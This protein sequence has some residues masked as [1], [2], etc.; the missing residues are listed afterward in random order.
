M[1][2]KFAS[3]L[4]KRVLS[5][6]LSLAM[7]VTLLPAAE[8]K[9]EPTENQLLKARSTNG[10]EGKTFTRNQPFIS[11]ITGATEDGAGRPYFNAP[12]F[13]V[14]ETLNDS[15]I[16]DCTVKTAQ[17][18]VLIAAAE[19]RFDQEKKAGGTDVIAAVSK[20]QGAT[21]TYSYPLRF[22]DSEGN[23]GVHATSINN[24]TLTVAADG[25][26]YCLMNVTPTGVSSLA[27]TGDG[28]KYPNVGTGYIE[29][30]G[31]QRLALTTSTATADQS[32]DTYAYYVA[33]WNPD[34]GLAKVLSVSSN[35]ESDYAVD[36]WYNLYKK[37]GSGEY[38]E[39]TQKRADS[40]GNA[41][42]SGDVQQNVFYAGSELHVYNTSYVVCVTSSDGLSWSAP[43]ILNPYVKKADGKSLVVAGGKGLTTSKN[44][45]VFPVYRNNDG[46]D[47]DGTS[48]VI[49]L[50]KSTGGDGQWHRSGNVPNFENAEETENNWIGE[51]EIVELSDGKLRMVFRN[52]QGLISY[53]DAQ[54]NAQNEFVFSA[55]VVTGTR[56][57]ERAHPSVISYLNPIEER[58]G[59]LIAAPVGDNRTHG[60]IMTFLAT[61]AGVEG[62]GGE[63]AV[64]SGMT[65]VEGADVPGSDAYFQNPCMDQFDAGNK[66]GLLWENG[67]GSIRFNKFGILDVVKEHYIP[68]V[69]VDL[70]M[71][72]GDVY[73]RSYTVV[74][75]NH[76]NGV[77]Q[78]PQNEDGTDDTSV[79]SVEFEKGQTVLETVPA[80]YSRTT[81]DD[82]ENGF[83]LVG[84]GSLSDTFLHADSDI[85]T[86]TDQTIERAEFTIT[87]TQSA[88]D[89][90]ERYV[91][92]APLDRRYFVGRDPKLNF[93]AV[94][95][96]EDVIITKTP[97]KYTSVGEAGKIGADEFAILLSGRVNMFNVPKLRFDGQGGWH[98]NKNQLDG[99]FTFLQKM[100]PDETL[101]GEDAALELIPGYKKVT[102]ITPN[103]KYLITFIPKANVQRGDYFSDESI[104]PIIV[105]YPRNGRA[106]QTK[107]VYGTRQVERR[108][109]KHLKITANGEGDATVVANHITYNVHVH[110][111]KLEMQKGEK[112]FFPGVTV[113]QFEIADSNVATA[114]T[115][116]MKEPSLFNCLR[117]ANNSLDGYSTEANTDINM[118]AAEFI[119]TAVEGSE[120]E[121]YTIQSAV[122]DKYLVNK[123]AQE[124]FGN[125]VITQKV[126]RSETLGAE[127]FEIRR[128]SSD[129][130]NGRYVY[131]YYNRMAF[132]AVDRKI[133]AGGVDMTT[134]GKFDFELLEKQEYPT[135][136]D[137]ISGYRRVTKITSGK[138]YLITQTY[139]DDE[140]GE[141]RFVLYPEN[142]ITAQ[143]KMYQDVETEGVQLKA[144]GNAGSK[145]TVT[146]DSRVY[147]LTVLAACD[148]VGYG[149][150]RIGAV[151][152]TCTKD[153]YEG[154]LYC[155]HCDEKIADGA[156]IPAGHDVPESSWQITTQP[157]FEKDGEYTGTCNRC[158]QE[159]TKTYTKEEYADRQ[160]NDKVVE[161]RALREAD[162]T[163]KSYAVL[164]AALAK[165][166]SVEDTAAAK[167]ALYDEITTAI[168]GLERLSEF[169]AAK[170]QLKT[171]LVSM[172]E[173]LGK[174]QAAFDPDVWTALNTAANELKADTIGIDLSGLADAAA[175]DAKLDTLALSVLNAAWEK[176]KDVSTN[177][178]EEAQE[179]AKRTQL[180]TDI[181]N[182]VNDA[183]PIIE[184]G[185]KNYTD[186]SWK[187]LTDA[188]NAANISDSSLNGKTTK[189]LEDLLTN[190]STAVENLAEKEDDEMVAAKE[191][192][193]EA[194]KEADGIVAAG[195]KNYSKATWDAFVAA[196][197]AAKNASADADAA[198]LKKL[199]EDLAKAQKALKVETG[200]VN[201]LVNGM[202]EDVNQIRYQVLDASKKT[203]T[204]KLGLNKKAGNIMIPATVKVRGVECSVTEISGNAFKGYNKAKKLTI[205]ANVTTIGKKAFIN[206][207]KLKT[208][209]LQSKVLKSVKGSAF[210][211]TAK[212]AKVKWPKGLKSSQKKKL[213]KAFKKSGLKMK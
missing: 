79:V 132:D 93:S 146:I 144:I 196:Y 151:E 40:S 38:V 88:E 167:K 189:E 123:D 184:G 172:K 67:S 20:D 200:T 134:C 120:A 156:V 104:T 136:L 73:E 9:A 143:S 153:G 52:G 44:R 185:Q 12:A 176:V 204:V 29:L 125:E 147:Y 90:N 27:E 28:F 179:E 192:V 161:A 105:L 188:Y 142:S 213:T 39:I 34:N 48:S 111:T 165:I 21:W 181:K 197:N 22:P 145:T 94:Q 133:S 64:T 10:V 70:D 150:Y 119:F 53:A 113:D 177:T 45:L 92:Y 137:Q 50:D 46:T 96:S 7:V 130:K 135:D 97:E 82:G 182:A 190:L 211:G 8:L 208:V 83:A 30:D 159:V 57:P 51:G 117:T 55:P 54:R 127:A 175:I 1:K 42:G 47:A 58:K 56:S 139:Q 160:L 85:E 198:T 36:R 86:Y 84:D 209:T 154:N 66:I 195:Q 186:D 193:A 206:C 163:A 205:G 31:T 157:S 16:G 41:H 178:L 15:T 102:E 116:T 180:K 4:W 32:P 166:N 74:G 25:T 128:V 13:V 108:A 152:A 162:Y 100:K 3:K 148:H 6:G 78:K 141:V 81:S 138:R 33:D 98:N 87:Q 210:K 18:T 199:A 49:W 91:L 11:N 212:G 155:E 101:E 68:H 183:K 122:N 169:N 164:S 35:T 107:L 63:E 194:V 60:R 149:R 75:A 140:R 203:V 89:G 65:R 37:N 202:T 24:P 43:E 61:G 19:G 118:T 174:E 207:K 71:T 69:T 99:G 121:L 59:L 114:E 77:T 103:E 124:Y 187:N 131:F 72:I 95:P 171:K 158:E 129:A 14:T 110:N 109:E 201:P 170:N 62:D 5:T 17:D 191:A 76:M 106:A 23:A 112:K 2:Q 80:L 115:H 173:A 26:I 126:S 168:E